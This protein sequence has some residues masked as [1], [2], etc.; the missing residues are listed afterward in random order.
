MPPLYHR[1]TS[2]LIHPLDATRL[3]IRLRTSL[4]AAECLLHYFDTRWQPVSLVRTAST[5][6]WH[7]YQ[8]VITPTSLPVK[9]YFSASTPSQTWIMDQN[10]CKSY[11]SK[12]S[13]VPF[14]YSWTSADVLQTPTWAQGAVFYQI[15][16]ERF[17]NG[18]PDNDSQDTKPWGGAPT[19]T[20]FF[21][22]DLQ[23]IINQIPYLVEL[24]VEAIWLNPIFT[25]T[26]NHKY[27]TVD[28][29]LVDPHF[30]NQALL[31]ELINSL[32]A[33]GIRLILDGVFNHTG[34]A[35]W[36]FQ[37]VLQHGENSP[38]ANWYHF[39]CYPVQCEPQPN[40]SCWWGISTLPQLNIGNPQ[41][42]RYLLDVAAHWTRLGI[43]GW[44]LDVPNEIEH[45]FWVEFRQVVRSINPEAYIVGEIWHDG[46]PWLRGNQFDAVMNYLWRD[47]VLDFF[48]R[49][50][51]SL[52]T[53]DRRL[54]HLRL[55]YPE[56]VA[57]CMLNLLDSHDTA[58]V[59]TV[60]K[61]HGQNS[62]QRLLTALIFQMT[63]PG[64]PLIYYGDEIG[65]QGEQDPDCRG[66]MIWEPARRDQAL[67][68]LY[69]R[70]IALRH[71]FKSLRAGSWQ[72]LLLD[73]PRNLYVYRRF[74]D[75]ENVVIALNLGPAQHLNLLLPAEMGHKGQV[76][77]ALH[78]QLHPVVERHVDL[79]LEANSG[80][81]LV[82]S[83][84]DSGS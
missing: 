5:G 28:Y 39:Q 14:S 65:M 43:D 60:F 26:S 57:A 4:S 9:Y 24:G 10:G 31:V 18:D 40:Y 11:S 33:H 50:R 78:G 66:C 72:T 63:S 64:S 52:S 34:T 38:Y 36:A 30:G 49:R 32:H 62:Q 77:E 23:G 59:A 37:D 68:T 55:L 13:L 81:I 8:V 74:L 71:R 48:A 35:F 29:L 19:R 73:E 15:F 21:G 25:S 42:R 22:G 2:R 17:A 79:L 47:L 44:R 84:S 16:P 54:A 20:S 69:R 76:L 51:C 67:L 1:I 56:Q 82:P 58:R 61:Q 6:R 53:F 75:N 27:D 83:D 80:V 12:T 70:L 45:S 7:Y 46:R 41:V 3:L